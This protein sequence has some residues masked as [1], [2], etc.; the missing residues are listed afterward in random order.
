MR[1][2]GQA[3]TEAVLVAALLAVIGLGVLAAIRAHPV[4]ATTVT[5]RA[6]AQA[7]VGITA[8][9]GALDLPASGDAAGIVAIASRL[10]RLGIH[11]TRTNA[12]PW[13]VTFTDGNADAWVADQ[14]WA[15]GGFGFVGPGFVESSIRKS[16]SAGQSSAAA[17]ARVSSSTCSDSL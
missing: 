13:I 12:G 10:L 11:E 15:P 6:T 14:V 17:A 2:R 3:A 7:P 9:G 5:A 1:Q 8:A 4:H 16:E